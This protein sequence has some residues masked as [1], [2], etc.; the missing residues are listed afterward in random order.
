MNHEYWYLSR[1]AGI[2]AYLLLFAAVA[3]GIATST[4]A[5]R[6]VFGQFAVF[7]LHRFLSIVALGMSLFHVYV[8]LGDGYFAYNFRQLTLP[9]LSPYRPWAVVAGTFALYALVIIVASFYL[10]RFIGYRTWRV[11][12]FA[13]FGLYALVTLHAITAGTDTQTPWAR[14]MYVVTGL[15]ILALIAYRVQYRIPDAPLVRTARVVG[16]TATIVVALV[17]FL[18]TGLLPSQSHPAVSADPG[19]SSSTGLAFF[20]AFDD[21][22]NGTYTQTADAASSHLVMQ[23]DMSGD[24]PL[25]LRIELAAQ[26]VVPT[27]D[28]EAGEA[29]EGTI[30][31]DEAQ[32][33]RPS[34]A[35]TVNRA[36]LIDPA[37]DNVVCD[38][39][40]TSFDEDYARIACTGDGPYQ[41]VT[42]Q[43]QTRFRASRDG[44]FVGQLSGEMSRQAAG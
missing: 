17:L 41:G 16:A 20:P 30:A 32:E 19:Q 15:V 18:A 10:R 14:T 35:V 37:S 40:I 27:P 21:D 23:G 29:G 22:L 36:Q 3:L 5:G 39:R 6:R 31:D 4:R 9:F 7:D 11:L 1:A 33:A 2:T 8:L 44:S 13:T 24:V 43:L 38:G 12:H 25:K 34:T 28:N 26:R 42:M